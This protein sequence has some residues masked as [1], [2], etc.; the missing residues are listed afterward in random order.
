MPA[1]DAQT[2]RNRAKLLMI[3]A[4]FLIPP[5]S[6]WVV[7]KSMSMSG[8]DS[9]TNA[10]TLIVPARPLELAGLELPD[11]SGLPPERLRGRW[12]YVVFASAGC[13]ERCREQ[14]YLTRQIRLGVN[15]D[16]RRVQRLLVLGRAPGSE[17]TE[18]LA[19]EHE[20]LTWT[21]ASSAAQRLLDRFRGEGFAPEGD[22]YFLIDPLGNLMMF[23]DAGVP[24]KGVLR[25]LKKLLKISQIG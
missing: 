25:D 24:A 13:D 8:A 17:A 1:P 2:R 5:V 23:Y 9:T 21:V 16:T 18:Y 15:K 20:D 6:A 3:I 7:W 12:V 19:E 4:L 11:A 22:Q 14:L 10:G